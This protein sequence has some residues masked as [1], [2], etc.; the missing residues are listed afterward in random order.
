[1]TGH[2]PTLQP[3]ILLQTDPSGVHPMFFGLRDHSTRFSIYPALATGMI[4]PE[5]LYMYHYHHE[6]REKALEK[7]KASSPLPTPSVHKIR[8][9]IRPR[10]G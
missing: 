1:M 5:W 8:I 6:E 3:H 4:Q 9:N 10:R 7:E 2:G